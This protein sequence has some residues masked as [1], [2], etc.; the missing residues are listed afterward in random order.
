M[1]YFGLL[2]IA[3]EARIAFQRTK[4]E[5]AGLV[6]KANTPSAHEQLICRLPGI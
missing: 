2:H 6:I 4:L 5:A 1:F 3:V